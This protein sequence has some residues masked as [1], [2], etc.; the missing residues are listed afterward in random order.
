MAGLEFLST[1][2]KCDTFFTS[3]V[4]RNKLVDIYFCFPQYV[5][6]FPACVTKSVSP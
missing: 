4:F 1:P 3:V 2:T 6:D 5:S